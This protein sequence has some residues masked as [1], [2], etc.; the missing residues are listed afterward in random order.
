MGNDVPAM[1]PSAGVVLFAR[2]VDMLAAFYRGVLDFAEVAH[3][4][5]HVVLRRADIELTVHAI[6]CSMASLG[7]RPSPPARRE[8]A[9]LKPVFVVADLALVRSRTAS[10]GGEMDAPE[11]DW[12]W[13]GARVVDGVDPEGNVFQLR[14]YGKQ[15]TPRSTEGRHLEYGAPVLAVADL[16]R[17]L[18]DYRERFGFAVEFVHRDFYASVV[19]DGCRIHLRCAPGAVRQRT[20][21]NP[22]SASMR[23]LVQAMPWRWLQISPDWARNLPCRCVRCRMAGSSAC[24]MATARFWRSSRVRGR[25]EAASMRS[26]VDNCRSFQWTHSRRVHAAPWSRRSAR[27]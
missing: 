23:A 10:F 12:W 7:G 13:Q 11:R 2:D 19:R 22:W 6:P 21:A 16:G 4:D 5:D 15:E 27:R 18:A 25:P 14:G 26:M 9:A 17:A 24:A 1:S 8:S 20:P 3:G